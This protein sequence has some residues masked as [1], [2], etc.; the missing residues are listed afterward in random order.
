MLRYVAITERMAL[1]DGSVAVHPSHKHSS[2]RVRAKRDA[3]ERD[4]ELWRSL[5]WLNVSET[6]LLIEWDF[7]FLE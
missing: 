6:F 1:C 7:F 3:W 2:S 5:P 4:T